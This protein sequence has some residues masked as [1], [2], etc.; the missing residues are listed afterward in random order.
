MIQLLDLAVQALDLLFQ[1]AALGLRL[2]ELLR[3][4]LVDGLAGTVRGPTKLVSLVM[5]V[6]Q[7]RPQLGGLGD[8]LGVV[9]LDG[10]QPCALGVRGLELLAMI[11]RRAGS[12]RARVGQLAGMTGNL[13]RL[14]AQL[15]V[16]LLNLVRQLR[17]F[18]FGARQLGG[19]ILVGIAG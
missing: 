18:D 15:G 5:G 10:S 1:L 2:G 8:Q 16:E 17:A 6:R 19:A 3:A 9:A 11:L 14:L 12:G 7:A 4:G 13:G